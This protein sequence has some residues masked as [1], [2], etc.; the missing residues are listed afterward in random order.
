MTVTV[1]E[2]IVDV[3]PWMSTEEISVDAGTQATANITD[4]VDT[5]QL[6]KAE[7]DAFD[8]S[9]FSRDGGRPE[10]GMDSE[11]TLRLGPVADA[12]VYAYSYRNWNQSNRGAYVGLTSGWHPTGGESRTYIRFDLSGIHPGR[13]G[14]AT[15]RLYHSNT[16]GDNY[17][18]LG[19]H[20]VTGNWGEGAGTYQPGEIERTAAAGEI[21]WVRQPS[22]DPNPVTQFNPGTGRGKMIEV[23]ITP[24]VEA[25]HSGAPNNGLVLKP[26]GSLSENTPE[27]VYHFCSREFDDVEYRPV[28]ILSK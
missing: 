21:S 2:G 4:I 28:L 3:R 20:Q 23:D 19:V 7:L 17:L 1:I 14:K 15:L 11:D 27:S 9:L 18:S 10:D 6:S 12:Y 25:W 16:G 26:S 8:A 24:L 22:F 5:R 13:F